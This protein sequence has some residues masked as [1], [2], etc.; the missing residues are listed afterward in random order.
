[1]EHELS[2]LESV[3]GDR[4][5]WP[6]ISTDFVDLGDVTIRKAI[7][8]FLA[9]LFL[10]NPSR[11]T[12]MRNFHNELCHAIE[13][14]PKD[15]FGSPTIDAIVI[16]KRKVPFAE[17][18]WEAYKRQTNQDFHHHFVKNI[19]ESAGKLA[20]ELMKKR[21]SMLFIDEPLFVTSTNPFIVI[22]LEMKPFQILG[23]GAKLMCPISPTRI[24][25][26]DEMNE[27]ANQYYPLQDKRAVGLYT[28]LTWI[29]TEG[30]M[31]SPRYMPL[32]LQEMLEFMDEEQR[33]QKVSQQRRS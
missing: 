1:M 25:C 26:L 17:I 32:V 30:F 29:N 27:P 2:K 20:N 7:A 24:L 31:I 13:S 3:L 19:R 4:W 12:D 5:F 6:R 10:R 8:L 18:E 21:W 14:S 11:R 28:C 33:R 22:D 16:G 9:T 15:V 23:K